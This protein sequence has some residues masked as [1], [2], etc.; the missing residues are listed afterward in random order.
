LTPDHNQADSSRSV[1]PHRDPTF[2]AVVELARSSAQPLD[3][4]ITGPS[5]V[6]QHTKQE[7]QSSDGSPVSSPGLSDRPVQFNL[8]PDVAAALL[9]HL[10]DIAEPTPSRSG[11]T[12]TL[13]MKKAPAATG[14]QSHS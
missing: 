9:R 5:L 8:E 12:K 13:R 3:W 2:D 11:K 6:K 14:A 1:L 4:R 7:H 10:I